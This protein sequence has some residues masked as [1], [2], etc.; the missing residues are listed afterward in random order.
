MFHQLE[1]HVLI[2]AKCIVNENIDFLEFIQYNVL[3][4]AK[5]IVNEG[6]FE[7]TAIPTTVL[8]VAKCIVNDID[9]STLF[10]VAVY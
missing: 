9:N 4:V 5:C 7:S 2:V 6:M 1:Q 8:I 10:E 3:I